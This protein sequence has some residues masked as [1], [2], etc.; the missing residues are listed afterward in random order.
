MRDTIDPH[1]P[2]PFPAGSRGKIAWLR[3]RAAARLPLWHPLD[4]C[5]QASPADPRN[6]NRLRPDFQHPLRLAI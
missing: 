4:N 6:R 3:A 2:C 1:L 5:A